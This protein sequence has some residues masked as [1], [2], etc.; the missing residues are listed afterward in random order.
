MK[1]ARLVGASMLLVLCAVASHPIHAYPKAGDAN[2]GSFVNWEAPHVHPLDITPDNR[3]L[4]AVNTADNRLM[5]FDVTGPGGT[6]VL[7]G[8]VPVGLDPVSVRASSNTEAWVV[9]YLSDTVSVVSLTNLVVTRTLDTGDEPADVAF[10]GRPRRA[11]VSCA[12]ASKLMVFNPSD[13]AAPPTVLDI[14]GEEPKA[15][16]VSLDQTKVYLAVFE[17]GNK[18]TSL[19]S[20]GQGLAVDDPQGPYGGQNPPPND[21]LSFKPPVNPSNPVAPPMGVIVRKNSE[22]RWVD[23]NIGDWTNFISGIH[24]VDTGRVF[25]WDIL[26]NDVAIIDTATLGVTYL[27]GMMN[28]AMALSVRPSDGQI[29]VVGTDATNTIRFEPN[30]K[31]RFIRV[32]LAIGSPAAPNAPTVLDL[33][34]HLTYTDE[35]IAT[36]SNPAT[37][38]QAFRDKSIGDPRAIVWMRT[39]LQAFVAG[40]GSNNVVVLDGAGARIGEPIPVGE[41]P[42]GLVLR[43]TR[44]YVLNKFA[45]SIS[46]VDTTTKLETGRVAFFDPTP[47]AIKLGRPFQYDTHRSSALGH[48]ACASCHVDS[49]TDRLGWDLGNPAGTMV[50]LGTNCNLGI[51]PNCSPE[52]HPMKGPMMTQTLQDIIG[53]EPHH[54]RGDKTGIEGFN[55][56]FTG[57]QGREVL[58]TSTEMQQYEDFLATIFYPPNP[59]RNF[60]NTI[61]ATISLA[62]HYSS[63]EFVS[64]GGLASGDPMPD[65]NWAPALESYRFTGQ[66]A[67]GPAGSVPGGSSCRMCHSLPTGGGAD[68]VFVGD[69]KKFPEPGSGMYVPVPTGPDGEHHQTISVLRFT[70]G[71]RTFKVPHFRNLYKK[72]GFEKTRPVSRSGFG[73]FHDGGETL[74]SFISRFPRMDSDQE[75]ADMLALLLAFSGSD[76]PEGALDN[77]LEPPGPQSNDAHAAVGKQLTFRGANNGDAAAIALLAQMTGLADAGK[78]GLVAKGRR[79]GAQRGYVYTGGGVFQSDRAAETTTTDTLR[80]GSAAGSELT[81]TVVPYG[82]QTRIGIDRDVDGVF[83][84]DET[85]AVASAR[86]AG[87]NGHDI[88]SR[89]GSKDTRGRLGGKR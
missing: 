35:E 81:F 7:I 14:D 76:L 79:A 43:G 88:S 19:A 50:P 13:L 48:I 30:L 72:V 40:M 70:K 39:P 41:G 44:L 64:D 65:G 61:P 62:G 56:A 46:I 20:H 52:F 21:G 33:N 4:L 31:G 32:N 37:F 25:G 87:V 34:P 22:G 5:V 55:P 8:E 68:V 11:F 16:A 60:D 17:S 84:G 9:N 54:W 75:V 69:I 53:H 45:G 63:G 71:P 66:H 2:V 57:L 74:E 3:K 28:L 85:G 51:R 24:S 27:T 73:F 42:T 10:A 1:R 59:F 6:P 78:V 38:S 47:Q 36:Q 89:T 58:L 82:T 77:L 80:L 29:T 83:D 67:A 86:F 12:Q 23:D 26:D 18:T 49:R 15:L